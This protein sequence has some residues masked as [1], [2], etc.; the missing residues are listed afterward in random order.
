MSFS[1][2]NGRC[3][4]VVRMDYI[5]NVAVKPY[6]KAYL[7][8]NFGSP[9]DIRQEGEIWHLLGVLLSEGA[10]RKKPGGKMEK[11]ISGNFP[12]EVRLLVT[13]DMFFRYGSALGKP[14]VLRFNTF[15]EKR[16]KFFARS[17]IGYHHSL[18]MSVA[19]CIR[20]FQKM[21][22]FSEDVWAYDS[23]KKDFDRHGWTAGK[24]AVINFQREMSKIFLQIM[25]ESGTVLRVVNLKIEE[26]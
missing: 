19:S 1:L 3:S 26:V 24:K 7:E 25:S 13:K 21:F 10:G 17:F 8:N 23:I 14:E 15:L 20:N 5:I 18:G 6:I 16:I 12:E 22:G 9:V 4:F 11:V 2:K